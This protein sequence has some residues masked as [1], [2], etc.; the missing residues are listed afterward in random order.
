[1]GFSKQGYWSRLPCSPPGDLLDSGME[2]RSLMSPA[3]AGGSFTTR[4]TREAQATMQ[5]AVK[6]WCFTFEAKLKTRLT[7]LPITFCYYH[8]WVWVLSYRQEEILSDILGAG[9]TGDLG[10]ILGGEDPLEKGMATHPSVLTW[11][12]PW[13]EEPG[14]LLSV[15]SK[16]VCANSQSS[17]CQQIQLWLWNSLTGFKRKILC[18][19]V[20]PG[21]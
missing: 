5:A 20:S 1:M 9:D 10:L 4:T 3:L 18:S 6:M 21:S 17:N 15:G 19:L 12:I 16:R 14:G 13:T 8:I 11:R 7:D 2:P